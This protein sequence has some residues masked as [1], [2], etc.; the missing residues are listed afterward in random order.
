[1]VAAILLRPTK[2]LAL[3]LQMV[4]RALRPAPTKDRALILDHAGNTFRFGL[5]DAPR[6]WSLEG[7]ARDEDARAVAPVKRCEC[8]AIVSIAAVVCPECG[9]QQRVI[10]PAHGERHVGPL[11]ETGRLAAMS[12]GQALRWA[13][14]DKHRLHLVAQARGYKPGWVWHRLQEMAE[15]EQ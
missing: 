1:V 14:P 7:K 9:A 2:S 5:A 11:I 8:G 10:G 12:Y 15:A 13:G 3:Y 6:R 4:G